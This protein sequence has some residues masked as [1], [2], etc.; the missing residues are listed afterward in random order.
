M[1]KWLTGIVGTVIAGVLVYW[2]TVGIQ[3]D[4]VPTESGPKLTPPAKPTPPSQPAAPKTDPRVQVEKLAG[5]WCRAWLAG[6]VDTFV[7]LSSE[8]FYFD[9]KVI[10][11][12]NDLRK[13]YEDLF[14]E[15]GHRWRTLE[16]LRIKV[17]IARELQEQGYDLTKDRIFKSLNL[18]LD[19]YAVRVGFRYQGREEGMLMMVRKT[20]NGFEV[21]GAWD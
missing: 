21:V 15:K 16:V 11:T 6:D 17:Q 20:A 13:A 12:K 14:R 8:P 18:S 19:D 10:L 7:N 2:L 4:R 9:Q 1:N 5:K 3:K